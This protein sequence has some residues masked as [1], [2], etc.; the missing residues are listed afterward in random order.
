MGDHRAR[1]GD[2]AYWKCGEMVFLATR[3]KIS[4]LEDSRKC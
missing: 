2:K 1:F 3:N 4:Y